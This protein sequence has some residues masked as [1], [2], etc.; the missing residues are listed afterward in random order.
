MEGTQEFT[1]YQ[2]QKNNKCVH[3]Q[4]ESEKCALFVTLKMFYYMSELNLN[5][6]WK[7]N[8]PSEYVNQIMLFWVFT[9][10]LVILA[11]W[12]FGTAYQFHFQESGSPRRVKTLL[13]TM[14]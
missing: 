10:R 4:V 12:H 6:A 13:Y 11:Y 9:Q 7:L 2:L 8:I 14:A 1:F 3:V 5:H